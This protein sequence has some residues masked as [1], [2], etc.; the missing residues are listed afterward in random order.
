MDDDIQLISD[1]R[2]LAIIGSERAVE[3]FVAA[4]GLPSRDLGLPRL[5]TLLSSGSAATQVGAEIAAS[6]GRWIKLTRESAQKLASGAP[7]KGSTANSSRALITKNGKISD[8]LEFSTKH[9]DVLTNPAV[10]TG[11]AGLMAQMAMQQAMD[12]ITEYLA[13]IDEKVEDVLRAQKDAVLADMIAAGMILD[14]AMVVRDRVGRVSEVTWSKVESMSFTIARTQ[15]YALRQLDALATKLEDERDVGALATAARKTEETTQEWLAVLARC[16]QLHDAAAVLELDRV[17][18]ATPEDLDNHRLALEAA[19]DNRIE[20]IANHTNQLLG[21]LDDAAAVANAKVLTHPRSAGGVVRARNQVTTRVDGFL[22]VLGL[23]SG[24]EAIEQRRWTEAA[25]DV[26]KRAVERGAEGV[27]VVKGF[28]S[29]RLTQ[30]KSTKD[31]LA[32][33]VPDVS[34]TIRRRKGRDAE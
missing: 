26:K 22:E 27:G 15:A 29:D 18:D 14:E 19:R 21:R 2:G 23:A 4:E 7:M 11:A 31:R 30:A 8:I 12:E 34:V 16:F 5:S 33:N 20:A 9:G 32:S 13:A 17:L 6:H 3:R 24:A 25:N 28:G 10:L 1:G